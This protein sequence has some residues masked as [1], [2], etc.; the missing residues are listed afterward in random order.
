MRISEEQREAGEI[1]ER[2]A[3][4][5]FVAVAG[6]ALLVLGGSEVTTDSLLYRHFGAEGADWA[7]RAIGALVALASGLWFVRCMR[8][9]RT[10]KQRRE[11]SLPP[12][13]PGDPV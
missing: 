6:L 12:F 5:F 4:A 7:P 11:R 8:R 2:A 3:V 10:L 9:L 13:R 1:G